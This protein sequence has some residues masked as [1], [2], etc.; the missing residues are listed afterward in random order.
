MKKHDVQR[1]RDKNGSRYL[2]RSH[3]K[4][5]EHGATSLKGRDKNVF[6]INLF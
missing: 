3:V 1:N 4:L 5:G 2:I 6:N